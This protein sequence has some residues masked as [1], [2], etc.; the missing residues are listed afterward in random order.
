MSRARRLTAILTCGLITLGIL[1]TPAGAANAAQ[2][3]PQQA[4]QVVQLG[5]AN[6]VKATTSEVSK[7][8]VVVADSSV[9]VTPYPSQYGS[10]S[11]ISNEFYGTPGYW[12]GLCQTNG[13]A[14]CNLIQVGQQITVPASAPQASAPV[15]VQAAQVEETPVQAPFSSS[16]AQQTIVNYALAQVGKPYSWAAAGPWSFDCSGLVM[17]ALAQVGIY[18]PHQDQGILYSGQGWPVSR[19]NLQPGDIV[20]PYNGH[21]FIYIGNGRIVEAATYSVGVV[22]NNLYGFMAARRFV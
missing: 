12:P 3:S 21:V 16:A 14:N 2:S 22:E 20:W 11:N 17:Q 1:A 4:T 9:T 13:I 5:T 8:A 19:D 18:V 6:V 15:A 10:L 7:S